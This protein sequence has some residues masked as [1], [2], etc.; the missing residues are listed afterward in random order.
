MHSKEADVRRMHLVVKGTAL[1]FVA[2]LAVAAAGGAVT[3]DPQTYYCFSVGNLAVG[4]QTLSVAA[5]DGG[6]D[7]LAYSDNTV[8]VL[9]GTQT[10][11]GNVQ[12]VLLSSDRLLVVDGDRFYLRVNGATL[13][14]AIRPASPGLELIISPK[15][16]IDLFEAL[17]SVLV[18]L[19]DVGIAGMDVD[20]DGYRTFA[21]NV[22]KGPPAPQDLAAKLD[23]ALYGLGVAEDWFAYASQKGLALLGLRIEVVVE[24]IPGGILPATFAAD[25][26]SETS[27][28]AS[29]VVP[30]DQ[31]V[32]LARSTDIGYVR[33]PYVPVVP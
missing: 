15:G 10:A 3:L 29:L 9:R 33:L 14:Y 7:V 26:I 27:T 6:F 32:S 24:K 8:S 30:V 1:A 12:Q 21:R 2:A 19:Q 13:S 11:S 22:L 4:I 31:L 28:V 5:A 20:V 17:T 16:S 18:E 25:M 23:Y